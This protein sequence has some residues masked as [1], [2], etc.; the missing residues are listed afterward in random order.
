M[1]LLIYRTIAYGE[2]K[3][4]QYGIERDYERAIEFNPEYT[5]SYN[6]RG[7]VIKK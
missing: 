5:N 2:L 7:T 6:N 4:R 1:H 3:E